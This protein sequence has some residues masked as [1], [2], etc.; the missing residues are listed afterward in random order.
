MSFADPVML[1]RTGLT[2]GR[3]GIGSSYGVPASAIEE[4]FERGLNYLYWGSFRREGMMR[5]IHNLAPRHRD[6]LVIAVQSYS[7]WVG[8]LNVSVRRALKSLKI[9]YADVLVL[10]LHNEP[11]SPRLVAAAIKLKEQGLVRFLAISCHHRPTFQ[12]YIREGE[13]DILQVRYNAAHRGAEN[14][15]FCYLPEH[16][17]PG[18]A[19]YT[20][21]RWGRLIHSRKIPSSLRRP[22]AVDCYRFVLT[23]PAV[24]M[25]MTG[26]KSAAQMRENLATLDA[27]PMSPEELAWIRQV[28]DAVHGR[29]RQ[30]V[31]RVR[32]AR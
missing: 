10:G 23:H 4:A 9:D 14:E 8:L 2:V 17:G 26:P 22:T 1:G 7:R 15:V 29:P 16:N 19:A 3:L 25:V 30:T 27:G 31:R 5:A 24:H 12:H 11:P 21:T 20:G 13:F 6:R 28:G 18:I 32:P